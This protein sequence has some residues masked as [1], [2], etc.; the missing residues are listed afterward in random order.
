LPAGAKFDLEFSLRVFEGDV[1]KDMVDF[2]KKGLSLLQKD[3]LGGSGTRGYGWVKVENLT[4]DGKP[5][6]LEDP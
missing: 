3:Y 6:N 4:V 1:E 5:S 2:I